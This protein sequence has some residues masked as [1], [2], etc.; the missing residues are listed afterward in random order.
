MKEV[1]ERCRWED[2]DWA[3]LGGLTWV[4]RGMRQCAIQQAYSM[5][6]EE[7]KRQEEAE[8]AAKRNMIEV[9]R[10]AHEE[11]E[12]I[13]ILPRLREV[14][15]GSTPHKTEHPNLSLNTLLHFL[16][17]PRLAAATIIGLTDL[18]FGAH[19]RK[20]SGMSSFSSSIRKSTFNNC[21]ATADALGYLVSFMPKLEYL[22]IRAPLRKV[23]NPNAHDFPCLTPRKFVPN[24]AEYCP[25]LQRLDLGPSNRCQQHG[26]DEW[27]NDLCVSS[28]SQLH[29]LEV[30][31]CRVEHFVGH[32]ICSGDGQ[33]IG[34]LGKERDNMK[35]WHEEAA[36]PINDELVVLKYMLPEGL[37]ELVVGVDS[38]AWKSFLEPLRVWIEGMDRGRAKLRW[39]ELRCGN[40]EV[41]KQIRVTKAFRGIVQACMARGIHGNLR[42]VE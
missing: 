26:T 27:D 31:W 1:E 17:P 16:Q 18:T 35:P 24:L 33:M 30:L 6:M 34:A 3:V 19:E 40:E 10:E 42:V 8:P 28:F 12:T 22:C 23:Y 38:R 36:K 41:R 15:I 29:N 21:N 39:I 2:E 37:R 5:V 32:W 4:G 11:E 7:N 13:Q 9:K 25:R 14:V 20:P